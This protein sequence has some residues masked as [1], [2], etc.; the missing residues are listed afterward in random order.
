MLRTRVHAHRS[1]RMPIHDS[2][3]SRSGTHWGSGRGDHGHSRIH[4]Y[5]TFRKYRHLL[6]ARGTEHT[7]SL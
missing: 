7:P 6:L 3:Q 1:M 5:S 2:T 4:H